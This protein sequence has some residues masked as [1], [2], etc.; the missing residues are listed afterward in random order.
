MAT[1]RGYKGQGRQYG[2]SNVSYYDTISAPELTIEILEKRHF[3]A[4]AWEKPAIKK[5]I[6]YQRS[7]IKEDIRYTRS[8]EKND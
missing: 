8:K 6:E 5:E 7:L 4:L 2:P 1:G 3:N